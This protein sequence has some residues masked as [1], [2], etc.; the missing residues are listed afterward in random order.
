MLARENRT[1]SKENQLDGLRELLYEFM[2]TKVR[3]R[4]STGFF[5]SPEAEILEFAE[6]LKTVSMTGELRS[7]E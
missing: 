3:E 7:Y 4:S 1:R 6:A 5:A 2:A